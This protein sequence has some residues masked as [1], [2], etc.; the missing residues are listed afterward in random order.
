MSMSLGPWLR[1][2]KA[3]AILLLLATG[4][5]T[6]YALVR[7]TRRAPTVATYDVKRGEFVDAIQF[8]GELKAMKS[9]TISA[10]PDA[11]DL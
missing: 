10:P 4:S 11:G 5:V 2:H 6:V 1:R 7:Y 3:T 9:L 8:R